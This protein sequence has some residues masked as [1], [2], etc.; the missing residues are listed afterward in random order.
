MSLAAAILTRMDVLHEPTSRL[1]I[2]S[3]ST[4][5]QPTYV[6]GN[7]LMLNLK[8]DSLMKSIKKILS[9]VLVLLAL[10][11]VTMSASADETMY[12]GAYPDTYLRRDESAQKPYLARMPYGSQVTYISSREVDGVSWSFIIYNDQFGYCKSKY[13]QP[14]NPYEGV[15]PHPQSMDESFGT[16]VL[17]KGNATPDYRVKNL[18]LCLIQAG[19]LAEEPGADGYFGSNTYKAVIK[20]QKYNN[21]YPA[22]KVGKTTKAVLWYRYGEYLQENGVIQ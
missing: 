2:K 6:A 4:N 8:G 14:E 5:G 7:L 11:S 21:L 10:L 13:L 1:S 18:Q 17:Q 12:I 19:Y 22:G 9:L 15:T 20:F 3:M 16:N